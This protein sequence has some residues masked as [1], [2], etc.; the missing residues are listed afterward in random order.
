MTTL[1]S[2]YRFDPLRQDHVI[3]APPRATRPRATRSVGSWG[4]ASPCPFC[5]GHEAETPPEILALRSDGSDANTPGWQVRVVPN[6]YPAVVTDEALLNT[7]PTSDTDSGRPLP[8][9]GS[10]E[11][12]VETPLH[13]ETMAVRS[14]DRLHLTLMVYRERLR[15]LRKDHRLMHV[16]IFKN[17]GRAAGATRQHPHSQIVATSTVPR[18]IALEFD[19]LADHQHRTS[20]CL[21]CERVEREIAEKIRL[22]HTSELYTAFCPY[23]SRVPFETCIVPTAHCRDYAETSDEELL[24]LAGILKRTVSALTSVVENLAFNLVLHTAP[25]EA[26][27]ANG[28]EVESH[29]RFELLPRVAHLAGFE[30]GTGMY[31]N[32][33]APEE[34]A[35]KLRAGL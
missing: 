4:E 5:P 34:A 25:T 27:T 1:V 22:V 20:R 28:V 13:E 16:Q 14:I 30:W 29:W 33:L 31:I 26:A 35:R 2:E 19:A 15:A 12:V 11:V 6:R 8:G 23:A 3:V 17:S 7:I 24:S 21:I 32:H 9:Y 18:A 10:H